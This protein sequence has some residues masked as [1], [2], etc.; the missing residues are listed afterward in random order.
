MVQLTA[1]PGMRR[2]ALRGGLHENQRTI[3]L[4]VIA[5]FSKERQGPGLPCLEKLLG[6]RT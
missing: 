6:L 1:S 5:S 4:G 3:S 2:R